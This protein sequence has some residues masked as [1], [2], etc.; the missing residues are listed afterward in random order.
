[1]APNKY[2][3]LLLFGLIVIALLVKPAYGNVGEIGQIQGS[4][5][6]ERGTDIVIEGDV[7]VGVQSM[8]E[9]VTANGTMRIDFVDETRVDITEQSRL[10]I[11]EFVYDP[12]NDIG[13]LS[14]KAS[15]GTVRYA[16]GQIAKKYKQNVKIRTPSA[17]IGV[18]GTDFVMVVDEFGGS[19]IT[20]LP[21]CDTAGMCYTGE[22]EVKTDAG[23]VVLNQAFQAT[24]TS[25][26]MR[27]P[28][29]PV[30]LDISEDMINNL[31]I[32]RKRTPIEDYN[33]EELREKRKLADFLGI[34]FL[35]FGDLEGD[36]LTESIEGIWVTALDETHFM[37]ADMLHDML[38]KLNEALAALFQDE[39]ARQNKRL[40]TNVPKVGFDPETQIRL[41]LEEPNWIWIREDFEQGGYIRLKLNNAYDYTLDIQQGEFFLYDYRLGSEGTNSITIIQTNN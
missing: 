18:R 7:G 22:I 24:A 23:F 32:L 10:V 9:A 5:V 20:L 8:D 12:A 6:L 30:K 15:L 40:L 16:S 33:E 35:E 31:L 17:T 26:S 34:D 28:T 14:I 1:M 25:H 19:M 38:D 36:A 29:P 37:L 41:D 21:S 27:K 4:G 39:L 11:D 13:S 3:W 2:T